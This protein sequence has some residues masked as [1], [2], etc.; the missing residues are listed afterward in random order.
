[1]KNAKN[2][3]MTDLK[4]NLGDV[5]TFKNGC[6]MEVKKLYTVGNGDIRPPYNLKG[7]FM[8]VAIEGAFGS[9]RILPASM[10]NQPQYYPN[11]EYKQSEL[12]KEVSHLNGNRI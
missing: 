12:L 7:G 3:T 6:K 4:V 10:E 9:L 11:A 2:T 8:L 5:F 1:M